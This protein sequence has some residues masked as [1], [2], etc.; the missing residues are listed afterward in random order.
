[1]YIL[2]FV[3]ILIATY[4]LYLR[5][6]KTIHE[7]YFWEKKGKLNRKTLGIISTVFFS[8]SAVIF[9]LKAGF[10]GGFCYGMIAFFTVASVIVLIRPL[11]TPE[12]PKNHARK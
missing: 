6:D 12:K 1:M 4:V 2:G 7:S 9:Y 3:L 5:S 8:A 10:L 11:M